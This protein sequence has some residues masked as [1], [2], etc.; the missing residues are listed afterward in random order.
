MVD[1]LRANAG[2]YGLVTANGGYLTKHSVGIY[3]TKP[4]EIAGNVPFVRE[5]PA[6]YQAEINATPHPEIVERPDGGATV[7]T[8]TVLFGRESTPEGAIII[9]RDS[10]NR[11]FVAHAPGDG[12]LLAAMTERDFL[13]ARG[14]VRSGD[15]TNIFTPAA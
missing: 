14:I 3:S 13:G 8:Y 2:D 11:R 9:G 12:D 15:S 7:E 10:K 4:T 1:V 5:D 6:A